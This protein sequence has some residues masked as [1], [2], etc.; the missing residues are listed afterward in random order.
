MNRTVLLLGRR[1]VRLALA[2][3]AMS[4]TEA[5]W[6]EE[7]TFDLGYFAYRATANDR[8]VGEAR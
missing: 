6:G 7:M 3:T 4:G 8:L 1:A 5:A 2:L